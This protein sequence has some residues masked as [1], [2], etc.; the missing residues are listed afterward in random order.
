MTYLSDFH[1]GWGDDLILVM[2]KVAIAYGQLEHVLKLAYKRVSGQT[3]ADAMEIAD[4]LRSNPAIAEQ[5]TQAFAK[6]FMH[7]ELEKKLDHM[8]ERILKV[9]G[10]RN[11]LLHGYWHRK[12]DSGE[13]RITKGDQKID[14]TASLAKEIATVFDEIVVLRDAL[15]LFTNDPIGKT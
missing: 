15:N 10:I 8:V 3:Y 13:L 12:I 6:R 9:N 7:Q 14:V 4:K 5:L 2:G 1:D 11:H